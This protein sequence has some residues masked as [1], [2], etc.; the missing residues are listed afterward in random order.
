[1][2]ARKDPREVVSDPQAR[3]FGIFVSERTLLPND[4]VRVGETR[5][6]DWLS[7]DTKDLPKAAVQPA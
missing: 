6:E 2:T 5:F 7:R 3:Y 1:L 4:D